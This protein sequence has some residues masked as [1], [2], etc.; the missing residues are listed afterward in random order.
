MRQ[1]GAR[2]HLRLDA[3]DAAL[4]AARVTR[5]TLPAFSAGPD[6]F[7]IDEGY[8]LG[9]RRFARRLS[10]GWARS[11]LKIGFTNQRRWKELGLDQPIWAPI[12]RETTLSERTALTIEEFVQPRIEPEIAFGFESPL[13]GG[14]GAAAIAR[15]IAWV[16]PAFEIVEC[17]FADWAIR[18]ADA[19]ADAGLHAALVVGRRTAISPD[20]ASALSGIDV[21]LMKDGDEAARGRGSDVLGGPVH[22]VAWLLQALPTGETI[23]AGDVVTT[24]T[25]TEALPIA[26]GQRWTL[27]LEGAP[28]VPEHEIWLRSA[29]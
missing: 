21:T 10:S 24:G 20:A 15:A 7:A 6:G 12:Y 23:S 25:L 4:E 28:G 11:G 27:R 17:H 18:P 14:A 3:L 5:T 16:A 9:V 26:P 19:V 29:V 22:A 1:T 8:E 13:A 2:D